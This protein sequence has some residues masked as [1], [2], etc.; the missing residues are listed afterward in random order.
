MVRRKVSATE[1]RPVFEA[2]WF[3]WLQS[4]MEGPSWTMTHNYFRSPSGRIVT[5]WPSGNLVYR[6]L[7]AVLG[8]ASETTRRRRERAS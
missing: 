4:R 1:V 2:L 5:Q 6:V 7:T 8:R 3:V